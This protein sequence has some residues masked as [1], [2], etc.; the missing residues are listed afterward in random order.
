MGSAFGL[1]T[2][3]RYENR[4][5]RGN[6]MRI[7]NVAID[8]PAGAGKSTIAKKA[9]AALR[10]VYIDTGAM[11]RAMAVYFLDYG[12]DK[13]D[14]KT[15]S[16]LCKDID[17]EIKYDAGNAQRVFL[18][19]VDVTDRLRSQ[20]VGDMASAISVYKDVRKNL[21]ALQRRLA[22]SQNVIMDGRDIA[23]VVLPYAEVKIYLTAS[24]DIRARRR[25]DE[26]TAKGIECDFEAV[27]NEIEER[28]WRDMHRENS[29]LV[30]VPEAVLIDSSDMTIDE[31]T[32]K[33]TELIKNVM[34]K[35]I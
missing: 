2:G 7:Y 22:E 10:F 9:A 29:P 27:K 15:I 31:V 20:E 32:E 17:I 8:G 30:R 35:D 23:S 19:R 18:E 16:E 5:K 34:A 4:I 26:L 25:Y 11:Y 12:I 33:V 24:S 3:S 14:E 1:L 6:N 13:N 21:V 28:D